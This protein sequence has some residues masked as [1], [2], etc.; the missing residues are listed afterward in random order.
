MTTMPFGIV[1]AG[2]VHSQPQ[3]FLFDIASLQQIYFFTGRVHYQLWLCR[4]FTKITRSSSL[5]L[6]VWR[7]HINNAAWLYCSR[8][9]WRHF[10]L[11]R[12]DR[13]WYKAKNTLN[14][15]RPS[16]IKKKFI[17]IF[18]CVLFKN[19]VLNII[20]WHYIN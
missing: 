20:Q 7:K 19:L 15:V 4:R 3:I 11:F 9:H 18:N 13:V 14:R 6:L 12:S 10:P 8:E 5:L 2:E 17:F 16:K 1:D